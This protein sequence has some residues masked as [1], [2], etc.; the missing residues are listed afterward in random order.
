MTRDELLSRYAAGERD[1]RRVNL[2]GVDLSEAILTE[3]N[4]A[5]ACLARASLVRVNLTEANLTGANLFRANLTKATLFYANLSYANLSG[6][7]LYEASLVGTILYEGDA[8]KVKVALPLL[9]TPSS[10][11]WG[12]PR[13]PD[14]LSGNRIVNG[15]LRAGGA[16]GDGDEGER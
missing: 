8:T 5:G 12:Q 10:P 2:R 7:N 15:W 16:T 3:A 6:A 4:L 1:F 11:V 13:P 9:A 14:A